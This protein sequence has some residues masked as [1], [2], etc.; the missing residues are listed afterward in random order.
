MKKFERK[1]KDAR[2]KGIRAN[3]IMWYEFAKFY[4]HL[5]N[6]TMVE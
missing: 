2:H 1:R 6:G 5:E 3:V 4:D